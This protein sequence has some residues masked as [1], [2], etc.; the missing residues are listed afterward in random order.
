[1]TLC[2]NPNCTNTENPSGIEHCQS[3][4][5][6]LLLNG[7]YEIV[8]SLGQG[9]F[10]ATFLARNAPLPGKPYCVIKQ[11]RPNSSAPN[12]LRMARDLF[13]RE[14]ATLSKIGSHPQIPTLMDYFEDGTGFYL[15]QEFIKGLTLHQ[16][17]KR[18]GLF[19][20]AGVKQILSE[21]MPMLE[22]LHNNQVIH[23][24]IKPA[25][26]IRRA[27]DRKLVMIDFGAVKDKVN[28]ISAT[29]S[30]QTALTSYAI[31]TPGYAPPEQMAMRPVY[32]SDIYAVGVTCIYLLTGKSPK[33][34]NYNP[35]T[36]EIMWQNHVHVS[37]HF[38]GVLRKMLEVSVKH[39]YQSAREVLQAMKLEPYMDSLNDGMMSKPLRNP[40]GDN[41]DNNPD[42]NGE[43]PQSPSSPSARMAQA[44]RARKQARQGK[45]GRLPGLGRPRLDQT[46]VRS[47]TSGIPRSHSSAYSSMA[48]Q[49]RRSGSMTG[50]MTGN[51]MGNLAGGG[52]T[53]GQTGGGARSDGATQGQTQGGR[54]VQPQRLH[55][56][57]L[58]KRYDRGDRDFTGIDFRASNLQRLGLAGA[59]FHETNFSGANLQGANLANTDLGHAGLRQARLRDASL[60]KAY[61]SHA[62]LQEADLRGADLSH[63]YLSHAN[64]RGANLGGANLTGAKVTDEQLAL[65]KLS[66]NTVF[67]NGRRGGI[68]GG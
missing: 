38:A 54:S 42:A 67:P 55:S 13:Q 51:A 39:R 8:R 14:A 44:I 1:M 56:Q 2:V 22:Y 63:A 12:V 36:G 11:L 3:C 25:N 18:Q 48:S 16:E 27:Q 64:L 49:S 33:D 17:V 5:S 19:S 28:P 26:I 20:E 53:N 37:D 65:A 68:F 46:Q 9:G 23:R 45:P 47:T 10:G 15:V 61:L 52:R 40:W 62:N 4:G 32:G 43:D 7:R 29:A 57:E 24:D 30:E 58:Q 59:N 34:M 6:P 31:G 41:L 35:A 60:V 21:L 66:W 50:N